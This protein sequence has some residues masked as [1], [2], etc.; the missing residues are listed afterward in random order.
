VLLRHLSDQN[1]SLIYISD[2][3]SQWGYS[4]EEFLTAKMVLQDIIH[5]GDLERV[6]E[7]LLRYKEQ[8][9]DQYEQEY[10]IITKDKQVRWVCDRT[11][12]VRDRDGQKLY[13]QGFLVDVT[14]L[15]QAEEKLAAS[16]KMHRR[17]LE[18]AG[19]GFA[20][21]DL[22]MQ[23]TEINQTYCNMLGYTREEIIGKTPLDLATPAF[24]EYILANLN[25]YTDQKYRVIEGELMAKD[26]RT[27]PVLIHGNTLRSEDGTVLCHV[28]FVSDMTEHKKALALA[29][30]VQK[31]LLPKEVPL[32]KDFDIAGKSVSCD[33]VGGDYFDF[34]PGVCE[35]SDNLCVAV[36]DISGHG[37]DAALL[38]ATARAFLRA[39]AQE[40]GSLGNIVADFNRHLTE[41]LYASGR[42]MT[43]FALALEPNKERISW[44]RA[45]HDP[46]LLYSPREDR[47][48]ELDGEGL[49]IVVENHTQYQEQHMKGLIPGQ[50]IT[51][52]T[53][54][55]WEALN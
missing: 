11:S 54:G 28:A 45:G 12:V 16:E 24:R 39:R 41:D 10:R 1:A 6:R 13:N 53:D 37:V 17:I 8:D 32:V 14:Q 47:F 34:L 52:G 31:S 23:Y 46:A 7:E 27:V 22:N 49:P 21:I 25:I 50:I 36:G 3:I 9:L 5:P 30:E 48:S 18:T 35:D 20:L 19:E 51:I 42:F 55:I 26:G 38:M 15:K 43:F 40:P 2:N 33:D 4:A 44:V 29:G